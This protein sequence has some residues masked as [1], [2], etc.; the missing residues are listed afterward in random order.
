MHHSAN[1]AQQVFLDIVD[2]LRS[3]SGADLVWVQY[4]SRSGEIRLLQS[5]D[6]FES[7]PL[8]WPRSACRAALDNGAAVMRTDYDMSQVVPTKTPLVF[9]RLV[10]RALKLNLGTVVVSVGWFRD[11]T[12]TPQ[13]EQ[14]IDLATKLAGA[15]MESDACCG[16]LCASYRGMIR[17][18]LTVLEMRDI[19]TI[20]HSRRVVT[21]TLLLAEQMGMAGGLYDELALG[22]ALHDVGKLAISD[23]ILRKPGQLSKAEF[24][25]VR[26]HPV[27]GYEMLRAPL[28]PFPT[29]LAMAKHHHERYVGTGY[30][31]G[32]AGRDI[33]LAARL[34]AVADAL[35]VMTHDRPYQRARPLDQALAEVRAHRGMQFCPQCTDALLDMEVD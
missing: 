4:V 22:A 31:A 10:C 29:A 28:K 13:D 7:P 16:E 8:A 12:L 15:A 6:V 35:D 25:L 23:A 20:A 24:A 18:L 19:E 1:W 14:L 21:Y 11:H 33:P 2:L 5:E 17:G 32:L 34:L 27:I 9:S 3:R 30:P 26:Q